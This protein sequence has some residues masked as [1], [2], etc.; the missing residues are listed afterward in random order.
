MAERECVHDAVEVKGFDNSLA[1]L[2]LQKG[3]IMLTEFSKAT[4]PC[5]MR[6]SIYL[7]QNDNGDVK[8]QAVQIKLAGED[9]EFKMGVVLCHQSGIRYTSQV[10]MEYNR[11]Q[12]LNASLGVR[13]GCKFIIPLTP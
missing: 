11:S 10:S 4:D 7:E 12:L 1:D 3:S 2:E 9:G 13:L 5:S 8:I 6:V